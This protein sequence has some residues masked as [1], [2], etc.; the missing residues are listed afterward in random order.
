MCRRITVCAGSQH[1]QAHEQFKSQ[2]LKSE[3][4]FYAIGNWFRGKKL[5]FDVIIIWI[6]IIKKMSYRKFDNIDRTQ[7]ITF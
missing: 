5:Y 3:F 1:P 2:K 7:G 4:E 6:F